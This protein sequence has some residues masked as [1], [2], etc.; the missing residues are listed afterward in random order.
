MKTY[1]LDAPALAAVLDHDSL[2]W[3]CASS[4]ERWDGCL[5]FYNQALTSRID[6]NHAG[7][8]RLLSGQAERIVGEIID[9]YHRFGAAPAAFVDYLATPLDLIP[10]LLEAG[11]QAWDGAVSDL[12]VYTGHGLDDS[13]P[14]PV[15]RVMTDQDRE[16][17][18]SITDVNDSVQ[19]NLLRNLYL[20]Q[21]ADS[22]LT[23]Y[24]LRFEE[25]PVA[26]CQLFSAGGIGRIEAVHTRLGFRG[27]GLASALI[28]FAI[29]DSLHWNRLT[30]LYAEPG[31]SPQQ[32]YLHLGFVNAVQNFIRSYLFQ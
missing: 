22:R 11:F 20:T 12:M 26:R 25:E 8:F 6:P 4:V 17:W 1:S 2:Y 16:D 19:Q 15:I 10:V 21:L 13:I 5:L 7:Q 31:G 14:Y 3:T 28:R 30:Y 23:A 18:A 9:F 27:R 32:L 29:Q 24:L